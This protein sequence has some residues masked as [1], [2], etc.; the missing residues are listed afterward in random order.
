MAVAAGVVTLAPSGVA[1][2][3]PSPQMVDLGTL[4]GA[5]SS[6]V[7][8]NDAG[9]VVGWS[10]TAAGAVHP[11]LWTQGAGMADLGSVGGQDTF[12]SAINARSQVTGYCTKG[13]GEP[14]PSFFWSRATGMIDRHARRT[15][16][17]GSGGEFCGLERRREHGCR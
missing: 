11:F 13:H 2:A 6:A 9:A 17:R 12:P 16:Q 5:N 15:A 8:V 14:C 4:G 1:G 3:R 10:E 7:A